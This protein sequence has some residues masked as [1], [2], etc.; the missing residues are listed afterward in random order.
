MISQA[1]L[2][3]AALAA[4]PAPAPAPAPDAGIVAPK[5]EPV[6]V[7]AEKPLDPEVKK[8]VDAMQKFYEETKDFQAEF[9]QTYHYKSFGRTSEE[10][11]KVL[12]AK[13]GP[14][15]RWDYQKP[16]VKV[17][18]VS[19]EKV[20]AYMKEAKQLIISRISADRLSASVTFLW[21]Q[22]KLE[23]EFRIGKAEH[24]D[25]KGGITLELVP[26]LVDPRFQRI[27]FLL[28]PKN[29]SVKETIVVDP[30]GSENHMAFTSVKT[31]AGVD[32]S[33]FA[34]NPPAD[35]KIDHMDG[36]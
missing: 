11:G 7:V 22:G 34:I 4:A 18:V 19:G 24:K 33:N 27:F 1:L 26:K 30:D 29:F 35:T 36:L 16:E 6:A 13:V 14:S 17:F 9:H 25:L 21:G 12:F 20:F 28:D 15:M 32:K 23:R 10:W 31:N 2:L 8:V 5:A 3:I